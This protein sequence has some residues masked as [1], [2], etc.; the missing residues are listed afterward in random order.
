[1]RRTATIATVYSALFFLAFAL[2]CVML[3]TDT[4]L[5]T[6][7]GTVQNGYYAHWYAVLVTTIADL[8]GAA[9]LVVVRSRVAIKGGVVGA[10]LLALI[11]VG[12]VFTYSSVGFTSAGDFANYLFGITYYGGDIRYLYDLLLAVY[13]VSLGFGAVALWSTRREVPAPG[14]AEGTSPA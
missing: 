4:N 13:L 6:D 10:G 1:M 9:L 5:R 12:D 8:V 14:V 11:F 7:F 2:S 3:V